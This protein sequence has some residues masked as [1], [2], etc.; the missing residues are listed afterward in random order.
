VTIKEK[1]SRGCSAIVQ[2]IGVSLFL[3]RCR[4]CGQDLVEPEEKIICSDCRQKICLTTENQCR[5][6]GKFLPDGIEICGS[7]LLQPPPFLRHISYAAYEDTLREIIILYKYGEVEALKTFLASLYMEILQ[8][9]LPAGF[10]AVVPVP[11]DRERRHGFMPVWTMGR[12]LARELKIEFLP[13]LLQKKKSTPP[14]V[15]L[16]QAQRKT[17]LNGAFTLA[18]KQKLAGK[19]ILLID[20]VTTTGTTIKKCAAV[21]IKSGARVTALTLAQSRL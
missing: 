19:K 5:T 16:S 6:C 2:M 21:L 14:Q 18:E 10:H 12:I 3:P 15:G 8:K 7:C 4:N 1:V 13:N 17:N 20:D 11:V 9:K